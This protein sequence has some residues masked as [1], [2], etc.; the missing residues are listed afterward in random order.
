M[1]NQNLVILQEVLEISKKW[2]PDTKL[3]F[4]DSLSQQLESKKTI[5]SQIMNSIDDSRKQIS[6]DRS[7]IE[8]HA[9]T[10]NL[11]GIESKFF[12]NKSIKRYFSGLFDSYGDEF[13]CHKKNLWEFQKQLG[14]ESKTFHETLD[15][16]KGTQEALGFLVWRNPWLKSRMNNI[17]HVPSV[18]FYL[19]DS[20][21]MGLNK[22]FKESSSVVAAN[23]SE[24]LIFSGI[25]TFFSVNFYWISFLFSFFLFLKKL[26]NFFL[27]L[28]TFFK[29]EEKT[30]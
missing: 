18:P 3:K 22:L 7:I 27:L 15:K 6:I 20:K 14:E 19:D 28:N 17:E 8:E 2:N 13:D 4:A 12:K 24:D 1:K 11:L 9:R 29:K 10:M 23:I 16:Y 5:L 26:F 25:V 30:M 21:K